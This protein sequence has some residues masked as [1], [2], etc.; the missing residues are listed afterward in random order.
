MT[1]AWQDLIFSVRLAAAGA[2]R[3]ILIHAAK[4]SAGSLPTIPTY[5]LLRQRLG[6]QQKILNLPL[7]PALNPGK[8]YL[9]H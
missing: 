7:N 3:L 5:Q 6:S 1:V 9:F 8:H 2:A 4:L